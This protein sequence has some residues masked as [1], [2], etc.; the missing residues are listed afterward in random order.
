M[1]IV[2]LN[3]TI[4]FV[5]LVALVRV[6]LRTVSSV[7]P[8][9]IMLPLAVSVTLTVLWVMF[10]LLLTNLMNMLTLLCVVSLCVFLVYLHT[11][12]LVLWPPR[13]LCV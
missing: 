7:P 2:V 12:R 10:L 8:V 4:W 11:D 6:R 9:A 1:V 13:W 3:W 5:V